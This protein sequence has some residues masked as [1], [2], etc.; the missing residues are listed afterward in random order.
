MELIEVEAVEDRSRPEGGYAVI[1]LRGAK[2]PPKSVRFRLEAVD[3]DSVLL[4]A[5]ALLEMVHEPLGVRVTEDGIAL[6][7][8]PGLADSAFLV[9][10]MP[11]TITL[12]DAGLCGEFLWPAVTPLARPKRRN[13]MTRRTVAQ[14]PAPVAATLPVA[15]PAGAPV[16]AALALPALA[17]VLATPTRAPRL[18]AV[19]QAESLS[20]RQAE[21]EPAPAAGMA[22]QGSSSPKMPAVILPTESGKEAGH[23]APNVEPGAIEAQTVSASPSPTPMV[24]K[25]PAA[26]VVADGA[27]APAGGVSERSG[28][29]GR[30]ETALSLPTA[31][32]S[33]SPVSSHSPSHSPSRA[34]VRWT[35]AHVIALTVAGLLGM[36]FAGLRL[37]D[38][39]VA[40]RVEVTAPAVMVPAIRP[41]SAGIYEV[42]ATEAVSPRGVIG[43]GV[44][45]ARALQLAHIHQHGPE[46]GRDR[47]EAIYWLKRYVNST[48]GTENTRIALTQLGSA[49]ARPT[50]EGDA[51]PEMARAIAAWELAA[52]MGDSVAMCFLATLHERGLGVAVDKAAAAVWMQRAGRGGACTL[53]G[54]TAG[55]PSP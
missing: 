24:P 15:A 37:L 11:L 54:A 25:R 31:S 10:G 9:P 28:K 18:P 4:E 26:A 43:D 35:P 23:P 2:A 6:E 44:S 41:S 8:G 38:L 33:T 14:P 20:E 19:L 32:P 53:A 21:E 16:P 42:L 3:A 45:P 52:A 1:V 29:A 46:A 50:R 49:Y 27:A 40:K 17:P 12:L 30:A 22:V 51:R 55:S 39:R 13:I 47:E 48:T 7:I 34:A 36:Q 5:R